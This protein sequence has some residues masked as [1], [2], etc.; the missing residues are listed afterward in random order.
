MALGGDILLVERLSSP[1]PQ[2]E[3]TPAQT[4]FI[5]SHKGWS[6][7]VGFHTRNVVHR[8]HHHIQLEA[9]ERS[10]A[11]GL[12]ISPVIGPKKPHDF[13]PGPIMKS[14]QLLLDFGQ[15][16]A[17]RALLGSF[18]TYSRYSG[19]REAVFT[20]ICRKNM[21]CSHFII[22]RDHTGVGKFYAPDANAIFFES[23]G[24]I[25]IEPVFFEPIG[26]DPKSAKYVSASNQGALEPI[27]GTLARKTLLAGERLPGWF[28]HDMVQDMLFEE[29]SKGN[30]VFYS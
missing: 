18:S 5:F 7:V 10:G 15:Y 25:G 17:G 23:I 6:K 20:A 22:G 9:I 4:R 27:S 26:Y 2:Y 1:Y 16:D 3:L 19:P 13:L 30:P 29:I 21:G 12:Y 8:V 11:D 24:D 28:M 14:Y